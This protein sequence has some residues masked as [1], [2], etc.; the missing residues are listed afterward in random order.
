[1]LDRKLLEEALEWVE[2]DNGIAANLGPLPEQ[3][4]F[5]ISIFD[6]VASTNQT[7]WELLAL[8]APPGTIL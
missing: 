5:S 7:V 2:S 1:M 8:G 6:K 4:K 3:F